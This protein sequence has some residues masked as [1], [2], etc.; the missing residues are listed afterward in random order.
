MVSTGQ[1]FTRVI[2][3][4]LVLSAIDAVAG[5]ALQAQPDPSILLSLGA[6]AWVAYGLARAGR[7]R[8]A[9]VAAAAMWVI[10]MGG[11]VLWA[12]LLV[13]WN[14]SVPWHPR[15]TAWMLSLVIAAPIVAAVAQVAGRRAASRAATNSAT[16]PAN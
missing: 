15:S 4:A 13:G 1:V 2:V 6:T 11:F 16:T 3:F 8:L 14:G 5:R 7:E 9:M 12:R 10:Y